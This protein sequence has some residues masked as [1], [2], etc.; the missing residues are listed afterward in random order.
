MNDLDTIAAICTAIA[1]G[2]GGIAII[3]ISGP[4]A[5]KIGASILGKP[6]NQIFESH[7]VMYG[8]V[9]DKLNKSLIDEVLV[10]FMKAPKSFTG[11]DVLEIHC[12]GGL[13]AVQ[14]VLEL[15]L[16]FPNTRRAEAG[17]FSQRAVLNGKMNVTKAESI[18]DLI[19]ARSH[20]AAQLAMAGID[21]GIQRQ[22]NNL[23]NELLDHLSEIEARIDFEEELPT[24][25]NEKLLEKIINVKV[26]LK[27]LIDDANQ[28]LYLKQ[29][30]NVAIIGR[31]NVGKSSLLNRLSKYERAIVTELP[32]TTRDI[33]ESNIIIKGVPIKLLDTAGIRNTKDKVEILGIKKSEETLLYCEL[34]LLIYDLNLG[35]TKA[36]EDLLLKIPDNTERLIVGNKID[37]LNANN[38]N[39]KDKLCDVKFSALS[40]EGEEEL[41]N[42]LLHKCGASGVESLTVA[43][44]NRQK[45]LA[46]LASVSLEK[47]E[48]SASNNLPWDFWT[49]DLRQAIQTLG[50]ITGE[51]ISESVLSRIFSRFCIGK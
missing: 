33:L 25:N 23:R 5:R 31:P 12:H 51:E 10:L 46:Y 3:R 45:D 16:S 41:I 18:N 37:C 4:D 27:K 17:E 30:I 50:E 34:I 24:L 28:A 29:G 38:N 20:K 42:K 6:K 26:S 43:L 35:W 32:G 21:G 2:Q 36:D 22:M 48:E 39:Y 7:K 13:I 44:N 40:G 8:H 15:I 49:I 9:I 47:V 1:I 19:A 14:R 11:E